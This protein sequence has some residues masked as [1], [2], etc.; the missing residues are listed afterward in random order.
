MGMWWDGVG[1]GGVGWGVR[2]GWGCS[3]NTVGVLLTDCVC[4][5]GGLW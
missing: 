2:S 5:G 3:G 4:V 1:W